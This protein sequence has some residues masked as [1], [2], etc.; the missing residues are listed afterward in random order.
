MGDELTVHQITYMFDV[1]V[2]PDS[3]EEEDRRYQA[4]CSRL[5]GC[6]VHA[7][8]EAAALRKMEQAIGIWLDVADGQLGD[9]P[10]SIEERIDALLPD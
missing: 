2:E 7:G 8:S 9:D 10:L 4:S 3:D 1:E 5:T 6:V